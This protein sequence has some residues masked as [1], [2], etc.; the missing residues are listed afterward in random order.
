RLEKLVLGD[1]SYVLQNLSRKGGDSGT[2]SDG[3]D[4]QFSDTL[5][6]P[7]REPAWKDDDD[8]VLRRVEDAIQMQGCRKRPFG[9]DLRDDYG[10]LMRRKFQT[11]VGEPTWAKL[12]SK[13]KGKRDPAVFFFQSCGNLIVRRSKDYLPKTTLDIKRLASLNSETR[14]EGPIVKAVEFHHKST[15]ALVAGLSGVASIF[16]VDGR[17][18]NKLASIHFDRFPVR[19]AKFSSDGEQFIVGSQHHTHFYCY[20]MMEGRTV[21][22]PVHHNTH[23]TNMKRFEVSPDGRLIAVC[24]KFGSIHLMT[25]ASKEWV[26]HLKA[27]NNVSDIAFNSD[28]SL[29]YSHGECGEVTVWDVRRRCCQ[30][31]FYDEG[32]LT[33]TRIAV[34]PNDQLLACGSSS[35]VVNVFDTKTLSGSVSAT[36]GTLSGVTPL[37]AVMFDSTSQVLA[38]ASDEKH[39]AVK[40]LHFPSMTVFSNFPSL[41]S[42]YGRVQEV[43]FSP[44]SG[45][46]SLTNNLSTA[47]LFR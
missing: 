38:M 13:T 25:S 42:S 35:G 17:S 37:K 9:V 2:D 46:F 47:F 30:A 28:G 39:N 29:L 5:A 16:Q 23:Q 15:V 1:A 21:K 12:T 31:R 20:D 40:M 27:N 36:G 34:S 10:E 41:N 32:C 22:V 4:V 18:N 3:S 26:G 11:M 7:R 19:C 6:S 44:N 33:G 43:A 8:C 45:Y 14:N 24:G